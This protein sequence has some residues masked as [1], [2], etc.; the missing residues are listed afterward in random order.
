MGCSVP[1]PEG[2]MQT[3]AEAMHAVAQQGLVAPT[4]H[5]APK[6]SAAY[7]SLDFLLEKTTV[8]CTLVP[9]SLVLPRVAQCPN[10]SLQGLTFSQLLIQ[11]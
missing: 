6:T 10:V 9:T 7:S 11:M 8:V 5:I 2:S 4:L 3:P 1:K